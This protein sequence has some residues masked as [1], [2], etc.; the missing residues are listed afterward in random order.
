MAEKF[1]GFMT[2]RMGLVGNSRQTTKESKAIT[3]E[4]YN[5]IL[6]AEAKKLKLKKIPVKPGQSPNEALQEY[7]SAA[8]DAKELRKAQLSYLKKERQYKL[9]LKKRPPIVSRQEIKSS[10][11]SIGSSIQAQKQSFDVARSRT[12]GTTARSIVE[13]PRRHLSQENFFEHKDELE[14]YGDEGLTF[15]DSNKKGNG[16]RTGS[17]FG[18]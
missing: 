1:W 8:N 16:Q 5:K 14:V 17:L 15:F 3:A 11:R 6:L 18:F 10:L 2:S 13:P 9:G 12:A 7:T 4:A